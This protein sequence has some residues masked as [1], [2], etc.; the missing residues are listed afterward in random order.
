MLAEMSKSWYIIL[1][2]IVKLNRQHE[3][4]SDTYWVLHVP[5]SDRQA[6]S[7]FIC[8]IVVDENRKKTIPKPQHPIFSGI[9]LGLVDRPQEP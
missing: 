5:Y 3:E 9:K 1:N 4:Y 2:G 8:V 6:C 7:R